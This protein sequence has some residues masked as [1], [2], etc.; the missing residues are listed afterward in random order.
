MYSVHYAHASTGELH[1]RPIINLK[2]HEGKAQF[3][4]IAEEISSLVKKIEAS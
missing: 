3:R 4:M 1:L 2:T